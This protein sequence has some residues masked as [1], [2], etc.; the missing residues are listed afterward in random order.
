MVMADSVRGEERHPPPPVVRV[1][2]S[3]ELFTGSREILIQHRNDY[4]RLKITKTGK[5]ILNK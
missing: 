2:N 1:L 5:L 3:E 4:Y